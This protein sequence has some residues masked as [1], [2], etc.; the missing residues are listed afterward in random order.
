MSIALY[1][2]LKK[3]LLFAVQLRTSEVFETSLIEKSVNE[4][5]KQT[6]VLEQSSSYLIRMIEKSVNETA[7]LTNVLEQS[8]EK[9]SNATIKLAN[10]LERSLLHP[11]HCEDGLLHDFGLQAGSKL[12]FLHRRTQGQSGKVYKV[13][14]NQGEQN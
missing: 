3:Y 9:S 1:L 13:F 2:T 5:A 11:S 8:I 12:W 7:K 10:V 14:T 4:T 6:N